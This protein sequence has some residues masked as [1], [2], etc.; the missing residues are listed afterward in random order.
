[1][2]KITLMLFAT[3]AFALTWQANAQFSF[4][5]VA[6]PTN[7]AQGSPVTLNIND[8]GNTAGVP[9]TGTYS[10]FSVSVDWTND[11]NAYSSEADLTMDTT[12]SSVLVNP[13][14]TG[15]L[16]SGDPTTITFD[17]D[18]DVVYDPSTDGTLDIV[19][20][21]SWS[22][23]SA[24]WSNI[25]VTIFPTPSCPDPSGL[26]GV[27][28]TT[29]TAELSW[30]AGGSET[31]WDVEVVDVTG[32][33]SAT[34]TPTASGVSNPYTASGLTEGNDYEFYVR[35]DC[36]GDTSTWSGPF[37]W[38]QNV[39]PSNDLCDNATTLECGTPLTGQT[40][41]AATGG[42]STSC[43]GSMGD[44]V[45]YLFVGNDSDVELTLNASVE[46]GQIGVYESTDGTCSGFT[47]GTCIASGGSGE[48]PVTVTFP[49]NSGTRY[50][51]R[52][53]NWI[54]GDPA[55]TFDLSAAC[56]PFPTCLEPSGMTAS[57]VTDT[58]AD[59]TWTAG[60]SE[61]AWNLEWAAGADFTPGTGA[62]DASDTA[63]GTPAYSAS[64]L[65][66]NT[67]YYIYY[68]ADCG[69]GDTS[70]WA[71][72]F[73]GTTLCSALTPD[74]TENF[75]TF[76]PDCWDEAGSGTPATGPSDLGTGSWSA[77]GWL[78]SGTTGAA[79][80]NLYTTGGEEWLL[81]PQFD[82][83]GGGFELAYSVGLTDFGNSNPPE[84]NGMGVDDEVQVLISSD[85]GATWTALRTYNQS[86]YPSHTGDNEIID[87][88]GYDGQTV[89]FAFW[90]TDGATDDT[91][92]YDFFVDDFIVRTPLACS[93]A[94]VD[95]STVSDDCGNSQFFVDVDITSVGD[96]TQISDGTNTYAISGTGILQ[97]GPFTAGTSVTLDVEHSDA[98]CDFS[99]GTFSFTCPPANDEPAGAIMLT[100]GPDFATNALT[101]QTNAG[102]TA[103]EVADPSIPSPTC[104]LYS[105]GD[106]WYMVT[107]PSDGNLIIETDADPTGSGGDSGMSVY[108]GSI[109]A[110]TQVGCNDDG[111]PGLYSQVV[112]QPAD[113]LADQTLYIRVFE[114]D[115]DA[116]INFQ[117]SAYSATLSTDEAEF[118]G[119]KYYP[120]PVNNTLSL[121]AQNT[122]DTVTVYNML[123]QQVMNVA[124]NAMSKDLDMSALNNGTYFVR[125]SINGAVE[126]FKIIKQ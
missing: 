123:G 11:N 48:N 119:F 83:T 60:G 61:T 111:G 124:P 86:D 64:G 10:S 36:G 21:Q 87:L 125:V 66:P 51:I 29:T 102:A 55:I 58:T 72:P 74:Y 116:I 113:G 28:L 50:Y 26:T 4:P 24:N 126:N 107:V 62:A 53:G 52:V 41:V 6:G 27:V 13:P 69:G 9:T 80:I 89:Q 40:T 54:N 85:G 14:S 30:T 16:S 15:A 76:L 110:F 79:K 103:S 49:A 63:A 23:S 45:W 109:G 82:L 39:P 42:S 71:G 20:N 95:S 93:S 81:S 12:G 75:D 98:A 43:V 121:S 88:S 117:V 57:T 67:T 104:S 19:L 33:G 120:N 78:N 114:Y 112:I 18:F 17:G 108:S 91:E 96:A 90:A 31:Q 46:E 2:R 100:P 84:L 56:T 44:D 25:V 70:A 106:I 38:S 92:D 101:G 65:M 5:A 7:V 97:V 22:G 35:A 59:L 1:M 34:G 77:D 122:I 73:V 37:S 99:L 94:V 3:L 118:A 32:G 105:G 47:L 115:N 8:A 68:Q